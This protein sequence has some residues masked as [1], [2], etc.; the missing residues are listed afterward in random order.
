[1]WTLDDLADQSGRTAVVTGANAGI[2]LETARV[3]A[4]HGANVVLAC[5]DVAKGETAADRIADETTI[6]RDRLRIVRLD[7]A[8]LASVRAAADEIL[9]SR[10]RLDLLVN[11]AG[12][13]AIPFARSE[14]GIHP[15]STAAAWHLSPPHL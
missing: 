14:D 12:V 7:L 3:L 6:E 8:S 2:G 9:A 15:R 11:N 13:M 1:M 10:P 4:A 5:R